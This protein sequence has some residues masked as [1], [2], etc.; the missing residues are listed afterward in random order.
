MSG[1]TEHLTI[2]EAFRLRTLLSKV[3]DR[4]ERSVINNIL[5]GY[6]DRIENAVAVA[7]ED[8]KFIK[9]YSSN[10]NSNS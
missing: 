9:E 10:T 6:Y 4:E 3:E 2:E 7:K 5:G 8:V 1:Q